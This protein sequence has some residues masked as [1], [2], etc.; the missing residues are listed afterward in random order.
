[1]AT[2]ERHIRVDGSPRVRLTCWGDFALTRLG[3]DEDLTPRGR[4]ARALLA[5]LALQG[6]RAVRR[7]RLTGLLWGDRAEP[8]A[9]AS[10]RQAVLELKPLTSGNIYALRVDRDQLSLDP[11]A[12]LTDLDE[13]DA[14]FR[15]GD[16]RAALALLPH[17]D[18]QLFTNLDGVDEGFDDWLR[19]ERARRAEELLEGLRDAAAAAARDGDAAAAR[20]LAV[21]LRELDPGAAPPPSAPLP[22]LPLI[23][24]AMPIP[25]SSAGRRR[26]PW[27]AMI[28]VL[29]LLVAGLAA[30]AFWRQPSAEPAPTVAVLPFRNLSG[31]DAAFAGGLSDEI[32]AR[33]A[34]EQGLRVAGRASARQVEGE[35]MDSQ[36]TARRLGVTHIL[37]GSVR[38][39]GGRV[40]IHVNLVRA[41]DGVNLWAETFDGTLD[42]IFTIQS[43]IGSQVVEMLLQRIARAPAPAAS[44]A[45]NGAVYSAYLTARTLI[46]DRNPRVMIE[47]RQQLERALQLD[48]NFAPAWSSLA[49]VK[50]WEG[51]KPGPEGARLRA[52]ALA[53]ARR[54][55]ALAPDLAEAHAVLGMII[56]FDD[57]AGQR[58]VQRAVALDPLN[59][60]Y[61]LWAGHAYGSQPDF[62]R[63]AVAYRRAFEIDPLWN[64]SYQIAIETAWRL[65]DAEG[66]R[67]V[68]QR[69][70]REGS[71]YD[72]QMA[73]AYLASVSGDLSGAAEAFRVAKSATTDVGKQTQAV[74]QRAKHLFQLG[75]IEAAIREWEA[76]RREWAHQQR[77]SLQMPEYPA[78]HLALS[79]GQLP[80]F[81][82]LAAANRVRDNASGDVLLEESVQRLIAAGRAGDAVRLYA[83][84][85]GLLGLRAGQPLPVSL[86]GFGR[87]APTV[88][89]ALI[90]AGQEQEAQRL[91]RHADGL[92]AAALRRSGDRA[93]AHF[94]AEAAQSWALL[95]RRDAALDALDRAVRNGWINTIIYAGD[96]VDELGDEPAFRSLRG[97]PR[98]EAIRAAHNGRIARERAETA[99]T[100]T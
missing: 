36:A 98:F 69:L 80:S 73:R 77:R 57:P 56:G 93:P 53:D 95:G 13:L 97:D 51:N 90:A 21:R 1:M 50:R 76:C 35:G 15:G 45:P 60:E 91:L 22:P 74:S 63:M 20:A 61:Q 4:K 83:G 87:A 71:R 88:A 59:A 30:V 47:A 75:L 94:L 5:Y 42:D 14:A 84:P 11:G 55:L 33:L 62:P 66:A 85:D 89:A 46:R 70:E 8:Q 41:A 65:G 17:P 6:G 29:F 67:A 3:S 79:R 24:A 68:V 58:H 9:R 96:L 82:E 19:I 23:P 92:I 100:L 34:R 39:S 16:Y 2:L 10:L 86:D 99:R 28:V 48:P 18:E 26:Q 52:E 43:R 40:R 78:G 38:S 54:A 7:E 72:A 12:V 25:R 44:P 32:T 37:D 31:L 81:A 49:Q 27:L 64:Y